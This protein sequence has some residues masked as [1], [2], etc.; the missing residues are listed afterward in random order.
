MARLPDFVIYD[1][2]GAAYG[3]VCC[4]PTVE[5]FTGAFNAANSTE[6]A[7]LRLSWELLSIQGAHGSPVSNAFFQDK[8]LAPMLSVAWSPNT[9][10]VHLE[11]VSY[12]VNRILDLMDEY[13]PEDPGAGGSGYGVGASGV[14]RWDAD[15]V[16]FISPPDP[17]DEWED[18]PLGGGGGDGGGGWDDGGGDLQRWL[19]PA[20]VVAGA[21]LYASRGR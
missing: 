4:P 18:V 11:A 17:N 13:A 5:G 14:Q 15:P 10:L 21:L 16:F 19:I 8:G 3:V 9:Q 20:A 7:K 1:N 12:L 2:N 6:R